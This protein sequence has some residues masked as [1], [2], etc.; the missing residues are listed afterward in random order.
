MEVQAHRRYLLVVVVLLLIQFGLG[1]KEWLNSST[2]W[3]ALLYLR[4]S[5]GLRGKDWPIKANPCSG[6]IGVK[7][8][9]GRV[10]GIT[11]SGLRRTQ[12][13][14]LSPRFA[15]DALANFT[16]LVLFNASG[17]LLPG[18]IPDWFGQSLVELQV[19]DLRSSSIV[20]PIPSSIGNLSKLTDLYLSGNSLTG[21]M[22]SALGLLS[23][24][25]VLDVS[26]NLLTGS[27]PPF[28]SSLNNLRR[29]ELASNF[30]S[31]PIPPSISTL[32]KLQ[33]LD[34]SD[35]SLTSSLPSELGNLS[36]LLVLD[37][38]NN[39]LTGAL[40]VDLRGLRNLEKMNIGDNGLEGPLPV[41]LFQSLSQLEILVLRGNKLDGRLNHDLL[42]HPKL[43]FL[44]VSNNNFTGFLP[45]FV[46]NSVVVFNFSNNVLYGHL[47]LPLELNG[48]IDL[49]GNYFQGVVVNKSPDAI[50]RGN[51]LDMEPDQR[52]FEACSLFYSER[53]LTFEGFKNGNPDEM[54]RGHVRNNRLKFI[55]VGLFGG[56]GFVVIFVLILAV[57][58]KFCGKGKANKRGKANVGPVPDGDS[59]SLP[60]D[61]VYFAGLGDSFTYDQMLH[62][63]RNFSK[64]NLIKHGHSGDLYKGFLEGGLPV[65]IKKV[66]MLYLKNE[67]YSLEL[68]FFSKVS[69]MRLVPFLGHC[70]EREDEKLLVYKCMPNGDLANCLH[71]ISSSEDDNVQSLDWI[72]RLKI[73]IGAAEALSYLHHECNPPVVHRDV[74]A[75]SIL[76]DDKFEV[77]LGSLSEACILDGD[78]HQNVFTRLRRKP[79]SSEQCSSGPSPASC[80]QDIYCFGKVLLELV[81]GKLG[82]S[83]AE[84]STTKEW[85]EHTLSNISI[86][87]KELVT[88]IV[89]PSLMIDDDLL[90]EVWAMSIIAK[91]CLNPKPS[92]RPLMRYILKA[93]ENPLKV[94]REESSSSGRLRTTS[95]RRSWS[96]AFHGSWRHSSSDV[97]RESGSGSK[98]GGRISSHG[99]CGYDFSSSN[100]RLSNE[101][102]P[103]PEEFRDVES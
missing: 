38:S 37:L 50:L 97:N 11:V 10:V 31:G 66:N 98:Q 81:T 58:L 74:Q 12:I 94:V 28:L 44:D 103:E 20:G 62:S 83:K 39:S 93:L 19:L 29:L 92:R 46:P 101:I 7:C 85:S 86:H 79:Q 53:T 23:Q 100:K 40:P 87:D 2:E 54:K 47:N 52:N 26:R 55:M 13:G 70:F 96:A 76:L 89:D 71:S 30:L 49:S 102:V 16:S 6:W 68:D 25:S 56:L 15:V 35:N 36:E 43:K 9:G 3:T 57:L 77:R 4:S 63:T 22:P 1:Q 80:S 88:K 45:S 82:I 8:K 75:S 59:P 84:D 18:S 42:S 72:I 91:S 61:P 60:K 32:K 67:M 99:S 78:Q 95:S 33:L 48:S 73:A 21:I 69:H 41:D 90:E 64:D 51:C 17:F 34:L 65:V 27:I 24:L 5:L 14:R